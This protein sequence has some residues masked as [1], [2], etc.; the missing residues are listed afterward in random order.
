MANDKKQNTEEVAQTV[1]RRAF[2]A[3]CGKFAAV[4]PPTVAL[5][6]S[7]SKESLAT[8]GSGYGGGHRPRRRRRHGSD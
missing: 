8:Y 2:L 5:M 4:T 1:D 7:T 3:K 6:L